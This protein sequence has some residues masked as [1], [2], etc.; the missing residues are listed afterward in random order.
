MEIIRCRGELFPRDDIFSTSFLS[1]DKFM[2]FHLAGSYKHD[3]VFCENVMR[4]KY[5]N[6]F[7]SVQGLTFWPFVILNLRK[8]QFATKL[9]PLTHSS[10]FY[11]IYRWAHEIDVNTSKT[12]TNCKRWNCGAVVFDSKRPSRKL[13]KP[14]QVIHFLKQKNVPIKI[15]KC[16]YFCK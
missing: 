6:Y 12:L 16:T 8:K 5:T 9:N 2:R 13:E 10:G 3:R 11:K 7:Y 14:Y 15:Y 1:F 4:E